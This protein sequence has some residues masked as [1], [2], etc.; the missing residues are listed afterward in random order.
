M[1][2]TQSGGASAT[3]N[4]FTTLLGLAG[5]LASVLVP[6]GA[7]VAGF[8][9]PQGIALLQQ[10][11]ARKSQTSSPQS[12]ISSEPSMAAKRRPTWICLP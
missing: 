6:G 4:T 2:D 1:S 3:G 8:T 9:V 12:R 5:T 10:L 11:W 7:L